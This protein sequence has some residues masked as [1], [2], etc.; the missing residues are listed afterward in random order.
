MKNIFLILF[1]L[2]GFSVKCQN[3]I[4]LS[5]GTNGEVRTMYT[6]STNGNLYVGGNF[7]RANDVT[8]IG[9][10]KWDGIN[11]YAMGLGNIFN[12][13]PVLAIT[14]HDNEIYAGGFCA[15]D[16]GLKKWNGTTW[17]T[18]GSGVNGSVVALEVYNNELFIGGVFDTI[19]G[20]PC[21]G[22]AK[23]D[24]NNYTPIGMP[25]IFIPP[26]AVTAICIYQGEIY[27]GG[28]FYT[29]AYPNDTIQNIIRYDGSNW[30]SAGGGMHGGMDNISC[31][32]I[33][34]NELY[35]AGT[36]TKAHGN[37]GNY[38]QK[39]D[40]TSWSE[41][42]GGVIGNG[43]VGNGQISDL[44]IYHN[45]LYAV[46]VFGYA[47]GIPAQYISKWDGTNWCGL[48]SFFDNT[49][50]CLGVYNDMLYVGGGFTTI[51]GD[52]MNFIAKWIGGNYVDTC[53]NISSVNEIPSQ[54]NTITVYPNPFS[55]FTTLVLSKPLFKATLLVYDIVGKEVWR[56]ENLTGR[57][58]KISRGGMSQGMYFF[59][60][61]DGNT[62]TGQGKMLI[63]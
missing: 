58:I 7:S 46:G 14:K 40:G 34:K 5:N 11:W 12:C 59:K 22:F 41:V 49:I 48:S 8:A 35:V 25:S 27:L 36:F 57:E 28:N 6:D 61:I 16:G 4:S 20:I 47:G 32:A 44:I 29:A 10:A 17:V 51:D 53:G 62:S 26:S 63:E 21:D 60:I 2:I 9:I 45:E 43:G 42:G 30:K 23:W 18:V 15:S 37:V 52:T 54:E 56:K 19:G 24:G 55:D 38:I 13:Y 33:F 39:W 1:I 3:W 31:F 50:G